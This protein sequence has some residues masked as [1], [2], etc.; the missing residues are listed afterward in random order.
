MDGCRERDARP[1]LCAD[2]FAEKVPSATGDECYAN[3]G[4]D[5]GFYSRFEVRVACGQ[6]AL[7]RVSHR[8][9]ALSDG[10]PT[11]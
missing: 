1:W 5:A 3:R 11:A 10:L 9:H 8:L 6:A 2:A 7:T 4:R